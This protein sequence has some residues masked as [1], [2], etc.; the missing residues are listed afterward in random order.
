MVH[1]LLHGDLAAAWH[2]NAVM[3]VSGLPMLAWLW[4]RWFR[5]DRQNRPTPPLD[6]RVGFTVLTVA[7]TWMLV[8]NL[9]A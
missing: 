2:F 9:I 4:Y 1:A 3:L 7:G 6:K 8:R 5:A